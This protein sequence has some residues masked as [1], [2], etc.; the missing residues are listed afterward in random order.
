[1]KDGRSVSKSATGQE[2]IWSFDALAQ[3]LQDVKPGL[4]ISGEQ[5]DALISDCANLDKL[6]NA[7]ALIDRTLVSA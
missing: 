2:F 4:P 7:T 1:L 5:Y 6:P 3:R